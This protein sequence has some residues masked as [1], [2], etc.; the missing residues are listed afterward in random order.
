MFRLDCINSCLIVVFIIFMEEKI[1]G[2]VS[3]IIPTYNRADLLLKTVRS[4]LGQTY[5]SLEVL[6]CDD[7]ST[8]NTKAVVA[9]LQDSRVR[10][11]ACGPAHGF[12]AYARNRG[13]DNARGEWLAFSDDDD[14]WLPAKLEAQLYF[15][16]KRHVGACCTNAWRTDYISKYEAYFGGSKDREYSFKDFYGRNPVI[17]SSMLVDA[18][19]FRSNARE[20]PPL[21]DVEDYACWFCIAYTHKIAYLANPLLYYY[22]DNP[23][24][25]RPKTGTFE[26]QRAR[27]VSFFFS[28]VREDARSVPFARLKVFL[29]SVYALLE[30]FSCRALY[31]VRRIA[32]RNV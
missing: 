26:E 8:D 6:V 3:V 32:G 2:L 12:P 17:C 18:S 28:W 20:F 14:C 21:K 7:G 24:S 19:M 30:D 9:S 5:R 4:I 22:D 1:L 10:Y 29:A 11:I 16:R 27:V 23:S 13:I 15:M 25:I 31:H